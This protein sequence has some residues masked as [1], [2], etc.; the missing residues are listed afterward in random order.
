MAEQTHNYIFINPNEDNGKMKEFKNKVVEVMAK[1]AY[2]H[3]KETEKSKII[4][5]ETKVK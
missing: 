3:F 4:N 2:E 5:S 1:A